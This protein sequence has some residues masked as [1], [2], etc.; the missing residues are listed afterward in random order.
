MRWEAGCEN[1]A[2]LWRELRAQG[3]TGSASFV[4][5]Q[6]RRWRVTPGS[7]SPFLNAE[8]IGCSMRHD[9]LHE[10]AG[11]AGLSGEAEDCVPLRRW[12]GRR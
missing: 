9:A 12:Y 5:Q 3:F 11:R 6:V 8:Y 2:A 7:K 1:A 10:T 4:R